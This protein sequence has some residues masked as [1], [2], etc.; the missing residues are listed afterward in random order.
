MN[1]DL[2]AAHI[3]L[4]LNHVP[5]I[6]FVFGLA[7]LVF[8][9]LLKSDHL[10]LASLTTLVGIALLSI[11]VY[12]T[13]S[14]AH[15]QIC[16]PLPSS[17]PCEDPSISLPL[18]QMHESLAFVSYVLIVFVGGL[19]WLGLW[20]FRRLKQVPTW[21]MAA[22]A[23]LGLITFGVVAQAANVGG[24][25]RHTEIRVSTETTE[26]PLGQDIANFINASPWSW[27][28]LE[29]IHMVGLTLLIGVVLLIDLKVLGFSPHLTY[30]TLDR[31][32]PWGILGFGLNAISGMLF[33]LTAAYQY[34]GNPSFEWKLVFL[35]AA[36]L[37][38]LLMT[39]DP[40]WEREGQPPPT[41]AKALAGSALALWVGV[42]F[43]GS[44]L[45]FI[46]QAF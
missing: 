31:L 38:M 4:L 41:Y 16:G 26:P 25:I 18:I 36:G 12:A 21:N 44:M 13:G 10:K 14:G 20:L 9:W 2:S 43:W 37:N 32:L 27:A 23:L 15:A 40:A 28:A 6:G 19:A 7:L 11:P 39:F 22:V 33:F 1:I 24:E 30:S 34:V 5:T 29:A 35:M 8:G 3:H 45:P 46:G 17:G 42:M